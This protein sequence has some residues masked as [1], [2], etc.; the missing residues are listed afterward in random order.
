M[1]S[2]LWTLAGNGGQQIVAFGVF[3]YLAHTL[4]AADF[5]LMALAAAVIDLLTVFGRFGQ[6]EALMQKGKIEDT[7]ASTSFWLLSAIGVGLMLAVIAVAQPMASAFG[8]P[9]VAAI[10]MI[11]APVPLLQNLGQVQEAYLRN[12]F[13]YRGLATRNFGAT[14]ISGAASVIAAAAGLGFYA[15]VIQKL[16]FTLVYTALVC[17]AFPWLP[18]LRFAASEAR[19]LLTVGFDV[20]VAN[21]INMLNPRIVD[22]FVGY[23]LGVVALGYL[24]IAWRLLDFI[25]QL[26]VQPISSVAISSLT[27]FS[28]DPARLKTSFLRYLQF[29]SLLT[30]PLA[31]GMGLLSNEILH[32]VAGS[33]WDQSA[34]L[35]ALLSAAALAMPV[36]FLFPPAMIAA[37]R[38]DLVRWLAIAQTLFVALVTFVT[39]QI[40][41][42][43]VIIF[44]VVRVYLFASINAWMMTRFV[45]LSW[46]ELA[47]RW[48]PPALATLAMAF[49]VWGVDHLIAGDGRLQRIVILGGAGACAYLLVLVLGDVLRIWPQYC[50]GIF[51]ALRDMFRRKV[52]VGAE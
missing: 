45:G 49:A 16:V 3:A 31:V 52:P 19:R 41:I 50:T 18:R 35:L 36:S 9:K 46:R 7:P 40:D 39:A 38:T 15:L 8:E 25:I 21:L 27:Q 37:G 43:T 29:L 6:V 48:A 26:V 17:V 12:A 44:H 14:L 20:V 2:S 32:I 10:L 28:N 33:Q 23:F 11:L 24:R 34:R 4:T 51:G 13:S 1:I 30:L 5:G 47:Y 22:F 42:V